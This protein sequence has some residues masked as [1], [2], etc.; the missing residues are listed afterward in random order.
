MVGNL[1]LAPDDPRARQ[2][3]GLINSAGP[4]TAALRAAGVRFVV[5]DAAPPDARDPQDAQD[6]PAG[7]RLPGCTTLY[8]EP[9][10]VVYQ[11]P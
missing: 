4:L 7:V 9:D 2:L 8:N 1:A 5:V 6:T 11:V 10:L 3:D